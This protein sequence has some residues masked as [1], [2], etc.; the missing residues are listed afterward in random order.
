M[1]SPQPSKADVD[2]GLSE[3]INLS[4]KLRM[5][6]H[7]VALFAAMSLQSDQNG[8]ARELRKAV[9]EFD[10]IAR[11]L[12]D[13]DPELNVSSAC[14]DHLRHQGA[15]DPGTLTELDRFLTLSEPFLRRGGEA[16]LIALADFVSGPLLTTLND[17]NE[18]IRGVLNDQLAREAAH[19]QKSQQIVADAAHEIR[20][21][22]ATARMLS[23]NV[24]IET[25]RLGETGAALEHIAQEIIGMTGAIGQLAARIGDLSRGH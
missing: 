21:I 1:T 4:G 8:H 2:A 22:G 25:N 10:R 16:D 15:I 23:L 14:V 24:M 17:L 7:R 18:R 13:G 11:A 6:S 5:L 12:R 9:D 19:S 3:L 20:N